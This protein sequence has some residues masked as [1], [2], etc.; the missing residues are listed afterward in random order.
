MLIVTMSNQGSPVQDRTIPF[1]RAG[2]QV[3]AK[4]V[5]ERSNQPCLAVES[6][7]IVLRWPDGR[8]QDLGYSPSVMSVLA[9]IDDVLLAVQ[10]AQKLIDINASK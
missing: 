9:A 1:P 2:N 7:M 5:T 4:T 10:G 3:G 6:G 8:V